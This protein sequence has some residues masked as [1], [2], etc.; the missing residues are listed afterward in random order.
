MSGSSRATLPTS[1]Q[2][3]EVRCRT[4]MASS[5]KLRAKLGFM[6]VV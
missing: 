4:A 5:V 1:I 2:P 3:R 6:T